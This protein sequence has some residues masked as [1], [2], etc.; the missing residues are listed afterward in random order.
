[1]ENQFLNEESL[2]LIKQA[3]KDGI[4]E[5]FKEAR[6]KKARHKTDPDLITTNDAFKIVT[7]SRFY[8]LLKVSPLRRIQRGSAPNSPKYLSK[9]RINKIQ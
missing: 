5:G 6:S 4:L 3:V 1:M 2:S 8:E 7:K 9:K